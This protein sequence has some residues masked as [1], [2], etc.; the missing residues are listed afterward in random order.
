LA[1]FECG[2]D[3]ATSSFGYRGWRYA[4]HSRGTD[5]ATVAGH[6]HQISSRINGTVSDVL[7]SDNQGSGKGRM[8]VSLIH[9]INKVQPSKASLA[10]SGSGG[11]LWYWWRLRMLAQRR[12]GGMFSS[13][14][15]SISTAEA[16]VR[17]ASRHPSPGA[18][19]SS[20][21]ICKGASGYNRYKSLYQGGFL[22]SS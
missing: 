14:M 18:G 8:L 9:G 10:V 16:A 2:R 13:A 11:A 19:S 21:A 22:A 7:V 3:H 20:R 17:N 5:N 12:R 15:A 6:I 1:A 4:F